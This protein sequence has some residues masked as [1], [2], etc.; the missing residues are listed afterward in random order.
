MSLIKTNNLTKTYRRFEK[1][2]GLRGSVKSLFNRKFVEKTAVDCFDLSVE[3]GEFVGLIGPNG[4]AE[5]LIGL[6]VL[7]VW[8]AA[9]LIIAQMTY[10]RMRMKYDGAGI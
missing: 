6:C 10:T 3:Q 8:M 9:M 2:P 7:L 1:A 4:A 5:G